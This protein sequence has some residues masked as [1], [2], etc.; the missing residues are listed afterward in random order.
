M[1][2]DRQ[3]KPKNSE[4]DLS[5]RDCGRPKPRVNWPEIARCLRG[6]RLVTKCRRVVTA[7]KCFVHGLF[8][9]SGAQWAGIAQS[10]QR[11]A[12]GW[13]VQGSNPGGGLIFRTRSDGPWRPP[14][15]LYSGYRV[16]P[17]GK[18][19]GAW[20]SPP[21]SSSA[22]AKERVDLY[23]YSTCGPSWPVIG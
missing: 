1:G 8:P 3:G 5:K 22:E 6:V 10:V 21:T 14:S 15:L 12:T 16:F 23:V 9:S 17:E 11:L 19:A 7:P 4:T 2:N 13:T 20:R 18:A